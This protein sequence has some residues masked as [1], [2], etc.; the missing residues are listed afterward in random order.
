MRL[1]EVG[2]YDIHDKTEAMSKAHLSLNLRAATNSHVT[3]PSLSLSFLICK[4]GVIRLEH[5]GLSVTCRISPFFCF[6]ILG[7]TMGLCLFRTQVSSSLEIQR[8]VRSKLMSQY[9]VS[10]WTI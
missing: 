10:L 8:E 3:L 6:F 2:Q 7:H 1:N 9:T 5:G 4:I